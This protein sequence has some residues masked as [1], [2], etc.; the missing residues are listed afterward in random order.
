MI[1]KILYPF[2]A[3]TTLLRHEDKDAPNFLKTNS[4]SESFQM[5]DLISSFIL[6]YVNEN[7]RVLMNTQLKCAPCYPMYAEYVK[8]LENLQSA[9]PGLAKVE[10]YGKAA[11]GTPLYAL[12]VTQNVQSDTSNK[13]AVLFTGLIH[14]REWATGKVVLQTAKNLLEGYGKDPD[15]TR[16]LNEAEVWFI[17]VVNPEG[18][19]YSRTV[20]SFWR[21]NR[22]VI[23]QDETACAPKGAPHKEIGIGVDLNRNFWDPKHKS[24]YRIFKDSPCSTEDD[25]GGSDDPS[26]EDYRGPYGASEPEVQALQNF[27]DSHKNLIGIIDLHSYGN[28][29]LYPWG[30]TRRKPKD[31]PLFLD[32]ANAMNKAG[33]NKFTIKQSVGLYP[34]TG[35]SDDYEYAKGIFNFTLEIGSRFHPSEVELNNLLEKVPKMNVAFLD[36]VL[37][38]KAILAFMR[39]AK[40]KS[41]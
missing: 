32:C 5:S 22:R 38:H 11:N 16:R 1:S 40:L 13:P 10:V 3:N 17:P 35:S 21:K 2:S 30:H 14:A 15:A 34:T 18:Y 39:Q 23:Y 28:Q 27:M 8:E 37:A 24:L 12:K 33:G 29:I 26:Q 6:G 7:K 19:D 36:W 41:A 9:Y 20:E 25:Y 31:E 4:P